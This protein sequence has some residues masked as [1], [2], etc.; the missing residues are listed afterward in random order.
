ME[1]PADDRTI[2]SPR[3]L[4]N[5]RCRVPALWAQPRRSLPAPERPALRSENFAPGPVNRVLPLAQLEPAIT[6][7]TNISLCPS[8]AEN[9]CVLWFPLKFMSLSNGISENKRLLFAI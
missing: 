5:L 3:F 1:V 8:P 7:R 6:D 2:Y 9:G 4:L